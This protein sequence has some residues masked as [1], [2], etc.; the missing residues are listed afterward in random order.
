MLRKRAFI[1]SVQLKEITLRMS[2]SPDLGHV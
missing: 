2:H 1:L